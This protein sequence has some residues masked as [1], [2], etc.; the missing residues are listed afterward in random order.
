M[1][2]FSI[3]ITSF[4][5][6]HALKRAIKSCLDQSFKSFEIIVVDDCSSDGTKSFLQN[7]DSNKIKFYFHK[8]NKGVVS[9][10]HTGSKL[11]RGSWI[12][13]LDSDHTLHPNVLES[14]NSKIIVIAL[15]D[16]SLR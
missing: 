12:I 11:C 7:L 10:R 9:S 8:K 3:V 16:E 5:R 1:P 4:N 6:I 15:L 14:L 13:N 2:I